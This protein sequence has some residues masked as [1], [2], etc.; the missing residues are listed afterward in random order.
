MQNK[1]VNY[2]KLLVLLLALLVAATGSVAV[3]LYS[4][5]EDVVLA[6]DYAPEEEQFAEVIPNDGTGKKDPAAGPSVSLTYSD[7]VTVDL[8]EKIASLM[9]AN[10]GKST[11]NI[12]LQIVVQ[13]EVI[14][15][16]GTL[17]PGNQ[18]KKIELLKGA[19]K[20]LTA[21]GY[22]GKFMVY[23]YDPVSQERTIVNTEIPILLT[24]KR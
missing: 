18:L 1:K 22:D 4:R 19:D 7:Q 20:K 9:F 11:H 5:G 10:P 8:D 21:G 6:P 23:F 24:V 13:D 16:S 12:V 14:A 3:W 2:K 15:Q 17:S